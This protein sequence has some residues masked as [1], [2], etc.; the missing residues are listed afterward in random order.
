MLHISVCT[1]EHDAERIGGKTLGMHQ[2]RGERAD[3]RASSAYSAK[4]DLPKP[5]SFRLTTDTP[6][7]RDVI[8]KK[9]FRIIFLSVG[10]NLDR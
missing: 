1:F 4:Y 7:I 9:S 6:E 3:A 10:K 8:R 5:A 2:S